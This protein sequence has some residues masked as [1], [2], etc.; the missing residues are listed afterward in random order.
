MVTKLVFDFDW[1]EKV[2]EIH[3]GEKHFINLYQITAK[4]LG[5][6]S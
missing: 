1:A 6:H 5:R 2:C 4:N 3:L